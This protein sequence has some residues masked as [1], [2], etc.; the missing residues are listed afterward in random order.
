[1]SLLTIA[2]II[3]SILLI[4]GIIFQHTGA[5]IEGALGGGSSYESA[6]ATRRGFDKFIFIT[7]IVLAAAF[8]VLGV[9]QII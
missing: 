4:I 1:M 8:G 6:H 9:L 2:Q 5:G 3:V 7:T